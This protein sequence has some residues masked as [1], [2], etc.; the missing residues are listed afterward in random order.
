MCYA[1]MRSPCGGMRVSNDSPE[2]GNTGGKASHLVGHVGS[3]L[4]GVVKQACQAVQ[5]RHQLV[6]L[7]RVHAAAVRYAQAALAVPRWNKVQRGWSTAPYGSFVATRPAVAAP[8]RPCALPPK[9][10]LQ[11]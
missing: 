1:L 3:P 7:V 4:D 2:A 10:Q 6:Q 5:Q 11:Q 8:V 9:P